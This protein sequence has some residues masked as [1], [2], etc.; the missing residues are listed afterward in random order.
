MTSKMTS[1]GLSYIDLKTLCTRD[2]FQVKKKKKKKNQ[3]E[4]NEQLRMTKSSK[5]VWEIVVFFV[6]KG[7]KSYMLVVQTVLGGVDIKT[8]WK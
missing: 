3:E 8:M 7:D 5:I 2:F 1:P 4:S 6:N